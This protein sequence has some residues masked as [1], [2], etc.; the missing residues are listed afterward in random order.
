[1]AELNSFG[2]FDFEIAIPQK[3]NLGSW[4]IE[5]TAMNA[6]ANLAN[7]SF[8][9]SFQIQEFRRPEFEVKAGN[10]SSGPHIVGGNAIM[11]V[12]AKYYSG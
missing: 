4:R 10:E 1:K 12:A 5:F 2:A 3:S 9:H 8:S 11:S 6:P 7:T